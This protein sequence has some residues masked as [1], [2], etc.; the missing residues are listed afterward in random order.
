LVLAVGE[1]PGYGKRA[2]ERLLADDE[3][4]DACLRAW[5]RHPGFQ[6]RILEMW[7]DEEGVSYA[8]KRLADRRSSLVGEVKEAAEYLAVLH[9]RSIAAAG[10]S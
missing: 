6:D 7:L 5:I 1:A 4:L 2:T 9:A 10:R 8:L 3:T